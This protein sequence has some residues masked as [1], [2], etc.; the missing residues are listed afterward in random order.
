MSLPSRFVRKISQEPQTLIFREEEA[1]A[2][3]LI[4]ER[5]RLEGRDPKQKSIDEMN[6]KQK[7][8]ASR[9]GNM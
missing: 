4:G 7:K 1:S 3:T 2:A 8:R 6:A 5:G 9:F